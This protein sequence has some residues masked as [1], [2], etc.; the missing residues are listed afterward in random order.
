MNERSQRLG[1]AGERIASRYLEQHGYEV[2]DKNV[3]R[4]EGEIDLVA[5]HGD[6]L[7]FV[8]VKL[9]TSRKMGAAVSAVS[10]AKGA[11][12]RQLAEAYSADHPDL[13]TTLRIDLVA[14]ELTVGGEV[15]QLNHVQNAVE[16]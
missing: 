14:I 9:R 16:G 4:R 15:G 12:L 10:P 8:E 2:V 5:L 1:A 7:V 3:R 11:R 6:T 13:P